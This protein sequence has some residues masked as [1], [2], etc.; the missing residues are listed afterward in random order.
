MI[1]LD[2]FTAEDLRVVILGIIVVRM[3]K[4]GFDSRS[5]V[6]SSQN[7]RYLSDRS[8]NYI[9]SGLLKLIRVNG[10]ASDITVLDKRFR[11]LSTFGLVERAVSINTLGLIVQFGP[12]EHVLRVIVLMVPNQRNPLS[13]TVLKCIAANHAAISALDV[14]FGGPSAEVIFLHSFYLHF[15]SAPEHLLHI[16]GSNL[17]RV[18]SAFL[19]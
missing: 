8:V 3:L 1:K 19:S 6:R 7:Q 15:E 5:L 4:H 16:F 9:T 17:A 18:R 14:I 13:I 12:T 2:I 11:L 10:Q